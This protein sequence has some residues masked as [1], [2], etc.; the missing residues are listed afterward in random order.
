MALYCTTDLYLAA[1]IQLD[2]G[3]KFDRVEDVHGFYAIIW[4]DERKILGSLA[5]LEAGTLAVKIK[6]F[7]CAHIALKKM[8]FEKEKEK[9]VQNENTSPD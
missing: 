8:I 6:Q 3:V 1:A 4:D 5:K 7:R 2:S 9:E